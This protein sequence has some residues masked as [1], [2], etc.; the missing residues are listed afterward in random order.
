[1]LRKLKFHTT[2][3]NLTLNLLVVGILVSQSLSS[4]FVLYAQGQ[5]DDII[6]DST[7]LE[8]QTE[9]D[10]YVVHQPIYPA[11]Y[12]D[13]YGAMLAKAQEIGVTLGQTEETSLEEN[14]EET[15]SQN[16]PTEMTLEEFNQ[17]F[18]EKGKNLGYE[19]N[20]LTMKD[21]SIPFVP[22]Y[23]N[24]GY[25]SDFEYLNTLL[26][27]NHA[28]AVGQNNIQTF[29]GH[30]YNLSNNGVFNPLADMDLLH[31][32]VE[33][34]VTNEDGLSKGYLITQTIDFLHPEQIYQ[35][36]GDDFMPNLAYNGNGSDMIYIQYCRWDISLGLLI[37]NIGYRIW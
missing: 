35:Y 31:E 26:D 4:P 29:F 8:H 18:P 17:S 28:V 11:S 22:D 19:A 3:K 27:Q 21:Y 9:D 24:L 23:G 5:T 12:P 20:T 36:Y 7:A 25:G 32:G 15:P 13:S 16:S 30:Y 33:V 1:M 14:K 37:T 6:Q 34:T 10:S 2:F